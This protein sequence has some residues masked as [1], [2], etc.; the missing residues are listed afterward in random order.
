MLPERYH[1]H[2]KKWIEE[3]LKKLPPFALRRAIEGY[4]KVFSESYNNEPI[5]YKKENKAR[6][7]ANTRLREYVE[8]II[9][10]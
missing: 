6:R 8:K 5:E 7:D 1:P 3:Q 2:D 10:M 4:D 9:A